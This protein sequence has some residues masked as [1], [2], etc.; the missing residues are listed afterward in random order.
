MYR[1]IV[2]RIIFFLENNNQ[3]LFTY[4]F[5]SLY[6]IGLEKNASIIRDRH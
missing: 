1:Y 5:Y 3:D 2:N 6:S 4:F